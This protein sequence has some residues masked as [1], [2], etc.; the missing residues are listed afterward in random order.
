MTQETDKS[1]RDFLER[2]ERGLVGE[3]AALPGQLAQRSRTCGSPRR[4]GRP[5]DALARRP[6]L[7]AGGHAVDADVVPAATFTQS[8]APSDPPPPKPT[9]QTIHN[10]PVRQNNSWEIAAHVHAEHER[11]NRAAAV[12]AATMMMMSR[13]TPLAL[14]TSVPQHLTM[15]ELVIGPDGALPRRRE[16]EA[17]ARIFPGRMG[18]RCT[19]RESEPAADQALPRQ[20]RRPS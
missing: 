13:D 16:C 15:K 5:G 11:R 6:T 12:G 14:R 4:Q 17:V 3:I 8:S 7:C 18:A 20:D 10:S 19:P 1:L 9:D 2:R